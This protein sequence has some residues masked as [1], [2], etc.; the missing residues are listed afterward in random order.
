MRQAH[1]GEHHDRLRSSLDLVPY[2]LIECGRG[3]TH[4]RQLAIPAGRI[5]RVAYV[6][7]QTRA[8]YR[9]TQAEIDAML[10]G[11]DRFGVEDDRARLRALPPRETHLALVKER[12]TNVRANVTFHGLDARNRGRVLVSAELPM[13]YPLGR[14]REPPEV[15]Y[16][17]P[18][19]GEGSTPARARTGKLEDHPFLKTLP[20]Y[21]Y[22]PTLGPANAA[23]KEPRPCASP[24]R[25]ISHTGRARATARDSRVVTMRAGSFAPTIPAATLRSGSAT[26]SL[27]RTVDRRTPSA[28]CGRSILTASD[29]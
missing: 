23:A 27:H 11:L 29:G 21:R 1:L 22:L 20:V 26:R 8:V 6:R 12:Y 25:T 19:A 10:A 9:K 3:H 15:V 13:L 24:C 16:P 5:A 7:A 14:S 2:D 18:R 17:P 4:G 28:N